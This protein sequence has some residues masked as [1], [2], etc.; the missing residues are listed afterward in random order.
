MAIARQR[1]LRKPGGQQGHSGKTLKTVAHP[2][3]RLVHS[4]GSPQCDCGCDL[5]NL[6]DEGHWERRQV[7]DLPPTVLEVTE[8]RVE[9]KTC[10]GCGRLHLGEFPAGVTSRVQYGA[11]VRALSVIV[12]AAARKNVDARYAVI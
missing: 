2:D 1:G 6:T 3:Y 12:D 8:H 10:P 4:V 9:Q 11:R 5:R 7:F